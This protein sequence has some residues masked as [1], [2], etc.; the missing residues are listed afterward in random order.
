[1]ETSNTR[2]KI[3]HAVALVID[4]NLILL[5]C[6]ALL[7]SSPQFKIEYLAL[8]RI[9][10]FSSPGV[11]LGLLGFLLIPLIQDF[12]FGGSSLGKRIMGLRVIEV[13]T[14]KRPRF[15]KSLL[16]NVTFYLIFLELLLVFVNGG[17]ALG[18]M[19]SGTA[20]VEKRSLSD[21]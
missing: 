16:R 14:G 9:E 18:D 1:M 7:V 20:V 12:L 6:M 10:M 4:W 2:T 21:G 19:I 8:P 13:K 11:I 15:I 3:K 17:T 5:I